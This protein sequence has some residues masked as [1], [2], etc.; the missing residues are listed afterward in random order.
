MLAKI[1][2]GL[3]AVGLLGFGV[4]AL[5]APVAVIAGANLAL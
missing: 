2:F 4:A 3:I 5:V 1:A